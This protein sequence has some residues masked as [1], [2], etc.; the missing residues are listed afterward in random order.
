MSNPRPSHLAQPLRSKRLWLPHKALSIYMWLLW[1]LLVNEISAGHVL[2]GGFLAWLIPYL[3][4]SFWPEEMV[5]RKP[6]VAGRFILLVLWD[7]VVA[8]AILAVRILGP[9][10]KLQPAFIEVPL[11]I[12]QDFAITLLASTISLTPG[13]VSADLSEDR[14]ALLVHVLHVDDADTTV[15][16]MKARYEAPLKEIFEC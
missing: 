11:D 10:R 6:G 12:K 4:Q 3:T 15:S 13:T 1:L 5:L 14:S 9:T 8:N 7:I 16:A 2:L